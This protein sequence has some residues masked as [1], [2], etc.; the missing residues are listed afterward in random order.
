VTNEHNPKEGKE[1]DHNE[2]KVFDWAQQGNLFN[3]QSNGHESLSGQQPQICQIVHTG[4][5]DW[6]L[7]EK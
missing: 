7:K 4:H 6:R 1:V 3:K 2:K 5:L